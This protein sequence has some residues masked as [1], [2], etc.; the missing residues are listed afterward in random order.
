MCVYCRKYPKSNAPKIS[1]MALKNRKD[2]EIKMEDTI[3]GILQIA[4]SYS[5]NLYFFFK[6]TFFNFPL[7]RR[8]TRKNVLPYIRLS[9]MRY[10][11]FPFTLHSFTSKNFL[12]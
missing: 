3:I 6:S 2:F 11:L 12:I 4:T 8:K 1:K 9:T 10:A 5:D 7:Y